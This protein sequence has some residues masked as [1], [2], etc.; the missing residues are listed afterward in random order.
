GYIW[1]GTNNGLNKFDAQKFTQYFHDAKDSNS[2]SDNEVMTILED[3]KGNIWIGTTFGLNL[4]DKESGKFKRFYAKENQS[5]Y[6]SN[7][8]DFPSYKYQP[9]NK[10]LTF[11][12]NEPAK[13]Y[14]ISN[15]NVKK[16]IED[17]DHNIWFATW[18]GG[19]NQLVQKDGTFIQHNEFP[20]AG[21]RE[22]NDIF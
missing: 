15:R 1:I 20:K 7:N 12:Q 14:S 5:N 3:R 22:V 19:I 6:L 10:K 21:Q 2:I 13:K 11:F 9:L 16:I 18:G 17:T 8:F 4:F